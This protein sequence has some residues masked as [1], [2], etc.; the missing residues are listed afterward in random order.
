MTYNY[1]TTTLLTTTQTST[2]FISTL[3][4]APQKNIMNASYYGIEYNKDELNLAKINLCKKATNACAASCLYHQGILKNSDFS[5]NRVKKARLK[6]TFKFLL[7]RDTFFQ[8]LI[9]EITALHKKASQLGLNLAIQLNGTSD[10]LWEKEA[11]EFKEIKYAN[12]MSYFKHIQFFDYTKYDVLKQRN[13]RPDNYH[14]TYS[15]AGM[16]KG[17]LVD[18]WEYLQILLNKE[19]DVAVILTKELKNQLLNAS[20]FKGYKIID[21][22][23]NHNRADDIIHRENKQGLILACEVDKKT[24]LIQNGFIL[25]SQDELE[26]YFS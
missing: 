18:S 9:K 17:K 20:T 7:Q 14:L 23:L 8:Q 6:R 15:R 26:T 19:I 12:I 11:F 3:Y 1:N 4:L 5:K 10:I 16:H 22:N 2:H 13:K 25:Q 24:T 21:A